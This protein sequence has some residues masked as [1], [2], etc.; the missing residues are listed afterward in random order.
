MHQELLCHLTQHSLQ[1]QLQLYHRLQLANNQTYYVAL[2]PNV[3]E[4]A[5]N[6]TITT[7]VIIILQLLH[8]NTI[9]CW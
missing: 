4:D 9:Y 5:S 7:L 1:I 3:V 8:Q 6:N 2:L